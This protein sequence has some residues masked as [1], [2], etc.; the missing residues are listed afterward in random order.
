M[1]T[2]ALL[3][4]SLCTFMT[5]VAINR[6]LTYVETGGQAATVRPWVWLLALFVAPAGGSVAWQWYFMINMRL[7]VVTETIITQL[8][9]DHALKIRLATESRQGNG[10]GS[11]IVGKITNLVSTD[12]GNITGGE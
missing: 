5:P 8:V 11:N 1:V 2:A 3:V 12:L 6:L 7:V 9:F 10:E 4:K